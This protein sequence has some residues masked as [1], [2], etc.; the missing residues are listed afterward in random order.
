MKGERSKTDCA[1]RLEGGELYGQWRIQCFKVGGING[2]GNRRGIPFPA[3]G[4]GALSLKI[5]NL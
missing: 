4:H 5:V 3:G 1:I 2:G